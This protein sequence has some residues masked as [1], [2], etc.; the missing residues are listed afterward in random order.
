MKNKRSKKIFIAI[1]SVIVTVIISICIYEKVTWKK[2]YYISEKNINIPI[3]IYHDIVKNE[4]DVEY[5]YMQT[6]Q[7]VFEEQISGLLKYGYKIIDYD[8]LIAYNKGEKKL[9]KHVCLV[10]FDDGYIGNYTIAANIIK[11]YNIPV[12]IFIVDNLVGTEGYMSWNQIRELKQTGLIDINSHG[13]EHSR[14]NELD[15]DKAV[16]DVKYAHSRIEEELGESVTK[17]FT[18]PY[19]LNSD[20]IVNKLQKEGFIQNFTDNKI[21]SSKNLNL[22]KLHRCYPL[23]DSI[24]KMLVK[25]LYR[26]IRYG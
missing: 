2:E 24:E 18:Y 21:N 26:R 12:T 6:T 9:P 11:K 22:S 19:G 3:F 10:D 17:V 25:V 8:D 16:S 5:D 7:K 15:S 23:D 14:F 13:K 1:I 20:E 4:S